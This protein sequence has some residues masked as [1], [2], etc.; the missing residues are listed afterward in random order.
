M[1]TTASAVRRGPWNKGK[2]VG[3]KTPLKVKDIWPFASG[4]RY[5]HA[6]RPCAIR[7]WR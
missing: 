7:P 2:L 4:S 6:P 5:K 3:P 1:D